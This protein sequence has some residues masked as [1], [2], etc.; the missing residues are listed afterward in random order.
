VPPPNLLDWEQFTY[1]FTATGATTTID[2]FNAVANTSQ[3]EVGLDN[4]VLTA[5]PE[6][7]SLP[8]L[9]TALAALGLLGS[10][11]RDAVAL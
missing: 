2:F 7:G 10:R 4:V 6:P 9:A 3:N 8:L 1:G 11:W 5:V